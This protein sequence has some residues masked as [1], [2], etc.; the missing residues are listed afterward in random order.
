MITYIQKKKK[1][2][3]FGD[4]PLTDKAVSLGLIV[5]DL[6]ISR[7]ILQVKAIDF[8]MALKIKRFE[9]ISGR[10]ICLH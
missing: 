5:N 4:F 10:I 2:I 1:K 3:H 7:T 8:S 6:P 9:R